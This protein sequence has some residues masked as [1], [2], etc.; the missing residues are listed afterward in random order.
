MLPESHCAL[1]KELPDALHDVQSW[2]PAMLIDNLDGQVR[3]INHLQADIALIECRLAQQ[4]RGTPACETL[5]KIPGVGLLMATAIVA[6]MDSPASSH[7]R[8]RVRAL[9]WA[10][11]ATD[12]YGRACAPTGISKWGNAYLRTL[13]MHGARSIVRSD[14]ATRWPWLSELLKRR[15]YSVV[16]AAVA[17]KLVR[18]GLGRAC[19][20][21][22]LASQRL[23]GSLRTPGNQ[24]SLFKESKR[25]RV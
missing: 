2:L 3:R 23:A 10:G 15:P 19:E 1:L 7:Q 16:V 6:S 17:N 25:P 4:L 14:R 21:A 13:L 11:S 12:R 18:T 24:L 9:G 8:P 22:G 20:G 5:A